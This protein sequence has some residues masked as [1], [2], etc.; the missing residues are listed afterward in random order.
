MN[1]LGQE[2]EKILPG[3]V[4]IGGANMGMVPLFA[5]L[6]CPSRTAIWTGYAAA[7]GQELLKSVYPAADAGIQAGNVPATLEATWQSTPTERGKYVATSSAG[8]FR[9]PDLNGVSVGTL[10]A[11]FLRGD[12]V[13]SAGT[14]GVIQPDELKNHSH[15]SSYYNVSNNAINNGFNNSSAYTPSYAGAAT[16]VSMTPSGGGTETR[17]LNVT[18]CWVIKLFGSVTNAGSAD[19]AELATA[20]AEMMA[21][22]AEIAARLKTEVW[23]SN[24]Y[25]WVSAGLVGAPGGEPHGLSGEFDVAILELTCIAP[26]NGY[27]IGDKLQ[28]IQGYSFQAADGMAITATSANT[29]NGRWGSIR[30]ASALN[31]ITGASANLGSANWR[32]RVRLVKWS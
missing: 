28:I 15:T 22:Y 17:P 12:G 3:D 10:G 32:G 21:K 1:Y 13:N 9:L 7:D 26:D 4:A 31:K 18:G 25:T 19:V 16:P 11:T 6:W 5:V 14:D 27:A 2:L 29:W 20:Y 8:K 30:I 23:I 24:E